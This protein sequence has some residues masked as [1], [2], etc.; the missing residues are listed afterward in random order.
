MAVL[1][2]LSG[3]TNCVN[4]RFG[5]NWNGEGMPKA[6]MSDKFEQER[7]NVTYLLFGKTWNTLALCHEGNGLGIQ[8]LGIWIVVKVLGCYARSFM[9]N[10]AALFKDQVYSQARKLA[11]K[12]RGELSKRQGESRITVGPGQGVLC[13]KGEIQ[14]NNAGERG[15]SSAVKSLF[16]ISHIE[17]LWVSLFH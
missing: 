16:L 8:I 6:C 15:S 11:C 5:E 3:T 17:V 14:N 7:W 9:S 12:Q 10:L 4:L 2:P 13:W 1:W